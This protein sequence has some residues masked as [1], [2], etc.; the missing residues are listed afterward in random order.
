MKKDKYNIDKDEDYLK[1]ISSNDCTGLIPSAPCS[2]EE[3]ENY[4]DLY[5]FSPTQVP[6]AKSNKNI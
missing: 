5:K 2:K 4:K 3:Y 6:A 1:A